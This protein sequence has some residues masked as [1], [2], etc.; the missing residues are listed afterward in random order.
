MWN[1]KGQ[2]ALITGGTKGIGSAAVMEFLKLGAEV[3]FT[4]RTGEDIIRV[5]EEL[6][7]KGYNVK[8][9]VADVTLAEDRQKIRSWIEEHWKALSILVN[10]AGTNIRKKAVEY[11]EEEYLKIAELNMLAPFALSRE[12]YPELK[13]APRAKVINVASS[14]AIQDVGSG[15]PYAMTK[16]AI[17]QLTRSLAVEWA[18]ENIRVNAV[19]P[20]YTHTP[21][22]ESVLSQKDRM[23]HILERTPLNRIAQPEEM[24][25]VI[26]FLAMD[27]SSYITGQNIVVDGGMSVKAL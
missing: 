4:A 25:A 15:A 9:M 27:K 5:E 17:L 14:A 1:L 21:L 23:R 22:T 18:S 7:A 3:L 13:K 8:G 16:S 19:S 26:A 6:L 24:A 20:W 10:N 12:L 2:T 11:S